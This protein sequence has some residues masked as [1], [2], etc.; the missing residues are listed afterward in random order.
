MWYLAGSLGFRCP[1]RSPTYPSYSSSASVVARLQTSTAAS[2]WPPLKQ[3]TY[4]G[5]ASSIRAKRL[6]QNPACLQNRSPLTG[7]CA[8]HR[9]LLRRTTSPPHLP[10]QL[11]F[12]TKTRRDRRG[13]KQSIRGWV[14]R[15]RRQQE[16]M[17]NTMVNQ[18]VSNFKIH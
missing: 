15:E 6:L 17:C 16:R 2:T 3:R 12:A 1:R 5:D 11:P 13:E 14:G 9:V 4:R 7:V 18:D 10:S 8:G